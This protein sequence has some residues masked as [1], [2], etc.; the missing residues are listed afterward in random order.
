M[1][2]K[3]W[4][5]TADGYLV[6][7]IKSKEYFLKNGKLFIVGKGTPADDLIQALVPSIIAKEMVKSEPALLKTAGD[8]IESLVR[9]L[10]I[11]K[12]QLE[13]A[14]KS[15]NSVLFAKRVAQRVRVLLAAKKLRD[16]KKKRVS[17]SLEANKT[18][19]FD[20]NK[21]VLPLNPAYDL[22]RT[23]KCPYGELKRN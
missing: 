15:W 14:D 11:K 10:L 20:K 2:F 1:Y 5:K 21:P 6:F 7:R 16:L 13:V 22:I 4:G 23:D 17:L 12:T 18:R 19:Y 8:E 3:R 9:G